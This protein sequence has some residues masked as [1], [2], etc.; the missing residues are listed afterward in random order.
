MVQSWT[1]NAVHTSHTQVRTP[2]EAQATS[3]LHM[4]SVEYMSEGTMQMPVDCRHEMRQRG[5]ITVLRRGVCLRSV[6]TLGGQASRSMFVNRKNLDE[7]SRSACCVQTSC[8]QT[9]SSC[10]VACEL[11]CLDSTEAVYGMV[12]Q[13]CLPVP[14]IIAG[15]AGAQSCAPLSILRQNWLAPGHS[16]QATTT[17]VARKSMLHTC[18]SLL[19]TTAKATST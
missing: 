14:F 19:D 13:L 1:C 10:N 16:A 2:C 6:G 5:T 4:P 3:V 11:A 8:S 9:N 15:N 12:C 18:K 7:R 17:D